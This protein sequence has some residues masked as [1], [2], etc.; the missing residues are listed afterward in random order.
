MGPRVA[1]EDELLLV[2]HQFSRDRARGVGFQQPIHLVGLFEMTASPQEIHQGQI[3]DF[4]SAGRALVRPDPF[5]N[6]S[7]GLS[8]QLPGFG[9]S[10]AS[11]QAH[12][13]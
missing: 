2:G 13:A 6:E 1:F 7:H 11:S 9:P 4:L 5:S 3:V 8:P 10:P 12:A